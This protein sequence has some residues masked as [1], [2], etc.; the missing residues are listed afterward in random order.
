MGLR[1][2][3]IRLPDFEDLG[4]VE[5]A[6]LYEASTTEMIFNQ[7]LLKMMHVCGVHDFSL[8]DVVKPDYPRV[9]RHF[10]AIINFAKFREERLERYQQ[11]I[12][13][14]DQLLDRK[15]KTEEEHARMEEQLVNLHTSMERD[16]PAV[17]RLT[18]EVEE[19]ENS[20][21]D[22]M[23]QREALDA[24]KHDIKQKATDVTDRLNQA[25]IDHELEAQENQRLQQQ[26]VR[27][28]ARLKKETE[29]QE[30]ELA[31]ERE[32]VVQQER[33]S[34]DLLVKLN[35]L[36]K[37]E[38]DVVKSIK[39]TQECTSE[40]SKCAA[41][42]KEIEANQEKVVR[43]QSILTD[44]TNQDQ[45]LRRQL[46][47]VTD[48]VARVNKAN[49]SKREQAEDELHDVRKERQAIERERMG[50]NKKIDACEQEIAELKNKLA[51][52]ERAHA[53]QISEFRN[54][55]A[56]LTE[57]VET[58]HHTLTKQLSEAIC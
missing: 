14:E 45:Q 52:A 57:N 1:R 22:M 40:F 33:K 27:S 34:R 37:V 18:K 26:I 38:A 54:A 58:Y 32:N 2:E 39:M 31:A 9:R 30:A 48:K 12:T 23:A 7:A 55:Y 29:E 49:D 50:V 20:I 56:L 36:E 43:A 21:K 44:K 13:E 46:T 42:Q 10:S 41:S 8:R 24:K 16:R 19:L 35:S 47:T 25:K 6:E 15:F 11:Y 51:A 17:D 5:H 3:D 28:P 4:V 53:K